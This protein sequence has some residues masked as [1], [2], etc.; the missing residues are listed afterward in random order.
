MV[1]IGTQVYRQTIDLW[2]IGREVDRG[3]DKR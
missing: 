3:I 1:D 2:V